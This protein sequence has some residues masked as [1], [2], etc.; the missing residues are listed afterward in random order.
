MLRI[1]YS[2]RSSKFSP[3]AP[4]EQTAQLIDVHHHG[5]SVNSITHVP[6]GYKL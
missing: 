1:I 3:E 4:S 2:F 5:P 6:N